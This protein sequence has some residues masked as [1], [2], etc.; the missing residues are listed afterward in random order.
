MLTKHWQ[1]GHLVYVAARDVSRGEWLTVKPGTYDETP[2]P[3]LGD[4]E[5]FTGAPHEYFD[6]RYIL[7][8]SI[9]GQAPREDKRSSAGQVWESVPMDDVAEVWIPYEAAPPMEG[10]VIILSGS[11]FDWI[12]FNMLKN[13]PM[14]PKFPPMSQE[15]DQRYLHYHSLVWP[16]DLRVKQAETGGAVPIDGLGF[17]AQVTHNTWTLATIQ[18]ASKVYGPNNVVFFVPDFRLQ[19]VD[20]KELA[21]KLHLCHSDAGQGMPR[22]ADLFYDSGFDDPSMTYELMTPEVDRLM[23]EYSLCCLEHLIE[24]QPQIKLVFWDAFFRDYVR[25]KSKLGGVE[26]EGRSLGVYNG[27]YDRLVDRY[28]GNVLD[29]KSYMTEE[30]LQ[31]VRRDERPGNS[32]IGPGLWRDSCGHPNELG[33]RWIMTVLSDVIKRSRTDPEA[34][35]VASPS[36]RMSPAEF[37]QMHVEASQ[38]RKFFR[39]SVEAHFYSTQ[40]GTANPHR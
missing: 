8:G 24:I 25:E 35:V 31:N 29:V 19:N 16:A 5:T 9:W 22:Y 34:M 10:R 37:A 4:D 11:H 27:M 30:I 38:A 12:G 23:I 33:Y 17:G 13:H 18:R 26:R 3:D 7:R 1:D 28:R 6:D 21:E 40:L 39:A 15:H 2:S 36:A 20:H 32:Q 14:K